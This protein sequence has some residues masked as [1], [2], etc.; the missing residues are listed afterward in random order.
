VVK[1]FASGKREGG[2]FVA[3]NVS[4]RGDYIYCLGE[5]STLYCF[6]VA[7]NKLEHVMPVSPDAGH[8]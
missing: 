8:V 6:S 1:S 2:D 4:P 5:D 3:C 7:G